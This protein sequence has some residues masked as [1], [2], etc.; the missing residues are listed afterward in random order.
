MAACR[1]DGIGIAP[2]FA[3]DRKE[4]RWASFGE[5]RIGENGSR[6]EAAAQ[7]TTRSFFTMSASLEKSKFACTVQVRY[8][9]SR[10]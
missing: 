1:S 5:G 7:A 6:D 9:M 2:D 3:I 4:N 10:P 8:I